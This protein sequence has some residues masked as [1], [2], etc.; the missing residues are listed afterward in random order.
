[1]HAPLQKKE[2]PRG[3]TQRSSSRPTP[4]RTPPSLRL[5]RALGNQG[6]G[7]FIQTR[8]E[9]GQPGVTPASGA[10]VQRKGEQEAQMQRKPLAGAITPLVQRGMDE[11]EEVRAKEGSGTAGG[12]KKN[13]T[14]LPDRLKAGVE[15]L[16]GL[17]MDDVSVH[18]NS[19]KPAQLQAVEG[20]SLA[21]SAGEVREVVEHVRS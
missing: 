9:V 10:L 16:S 11:Q 1:M 13:K 19:A 4:Q 12:Y 15:T 14:G 20:S 2:T 17:S 7:Q 3:A 18:Y 6:Y 21:H 8:L 5:H